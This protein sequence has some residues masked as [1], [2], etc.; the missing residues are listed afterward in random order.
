MSVEEAVVT[1][2]NIASTSPFI[3]PFDGANSREPVFEVLPFKCAL[4]T[5]LD[6]ASHAETPPPVRE[7][8]ET[9]MLNGG[10]YVF[11]T[12]FRLSFSILRA[13]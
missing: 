9:P 4:N 11:F 3:E 7:D 5:T 13:K 8:A 1:N 12:I 2:E 6:A 10:A